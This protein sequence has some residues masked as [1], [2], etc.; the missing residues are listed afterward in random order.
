MATRVRLVGNREVLIN[1]PP[2]PDT[3][4]GLGDRIEYMLTHTLYSI[5]AAMGEGIGVFAASILVKFLELIEPEVVDYLSPIID[6]ILALPGLPAGFRETLEKLKAPQGQV[7]GALLNSVVGGAGG[8]AA[9]SIVSALLAPVIFEIQKQTHPQRPSIADAFAMWYRGYPDTEIIKEWLLESGWSEEAIIAYEE[10][11]RARPGVGDLLQYYLRTT[12][13]PEGAREELSKRGFSGEDIDKLMELAK[14][15]P[16]PSDLIRMAVREAFNPQAIEQFDLD[17]EFPPEFAEWMQRQGYSEDWARKFWISHWQLPSLTMGYEMLHRGIIDEDTMRLLIKTADI[18]P[19]WRDKLIQ[20][21]YSPY[22]RV[23]VRRM[24]AA[25]V[26]GEAD[27][28]ANYRDLGYDHEH[29]LNLTAWTVAE[30]QARERD[31]TKTDILTAYRERRI[32]REQAVEY[33]TQLGYAEDEVE[34]LLSR[35]DYRLELEV[36]K[37]VKKT[38]KTLYVNHQI[39]VTD[40]YAELGAIDLNSD[41]IAALLRLW[42]IERNRKT[43]R[44][45]VS[46]LR[47][48]YLKSIID[49][50]TLR[51]ELAGHGYSDKYID[52]FIKLWTPGVGS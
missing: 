6:D 14:L 39:D 20:I 29:A 26:L 30:Y 22:T 4:D 28:Y 5:L 45:T 31:L 12:K 10:L 41:E 46:Q 36:E 11:A 23:D 33:L 47:D 51:K 27:V 32:R 21:S 7:G 2:R 1:E 37:E 52:W 18:S 49:E 17:Q 15:I 43:E 19:F 50:S 3:F 48:M 38:V 13:S 25:G 35:E 16:G 9:G 44:P 42:D 24:Y 34:V 8:Q 40:V